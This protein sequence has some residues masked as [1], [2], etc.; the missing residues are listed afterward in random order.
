MGGPMDACAYDRSTAAGSLPTGYDELMQSAVGKKPL[1]LA[2][3]EPF[4]QCDA[5]KLAAN[6]AWLQVAKKAEELPK[7]GLGEVE[8]GEILDLICDADDDLGEW[9]PFYDIE[10]KDGEV[11]LQKR[12]ELGEC[13][14]ECSTV[15]HACRAVFEEYRED[16]SE[17]LFKH[18]RLQGDGDGT[19]NRLSPEKFTS[20][21]CNKMSKVCP[22]KWPGGQGSVGA[23]GGMLTFQESKSRPELASKQK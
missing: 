3:T 6:E 2:K 17:M 18:Y 7:G 10:Q 19:K 21:L 22:G 11:T 16:L 8:I 20:R 13:R 14:K 4:I 5:C 1:R 12:E 23:V 9:I 15:I